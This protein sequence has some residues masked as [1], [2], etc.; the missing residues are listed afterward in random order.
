[1]RH[2]K[3]AVALAVAA[4]ALCVAAVPMASAHQFVASKTGKLK[5]RGFNE[6]NI[7]ATPISEWPE[8]EPERMQEF[9]FA[10][11]KILCF[12]ASDLNNETI[13]SE[14][15]ELES[16][17]LKFTTKYSKCA[18]YPFL[19]STAPPY[20]PE[21]LYHIAASM[22]KNGMTVEYHANGWVETQAEPEAEE[23]EYKGVLKPTSL[24]F[25]IGS[26]KICA[27]YVPEQTIPIKAIK[28]PEEEFS[29]VTYSNLEV[30]T[31]KLKTFPSGFQQRLLINDAWKHIQFKYGLSGGEEPEVK[32]QCETYGKE[33]LQEGSSSGIYKG[34]LEQEIG[35]GNLR[36]E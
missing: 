21:T 24:S 34:H 31:E 27:I 36:Y 14:V 3:L 35:G 22:S 28:K 20:N 5:G 16:N 6:I 9:H 13:H 17:V 19:P 32:Y 12:K 11:F 23:I 25:K 15:T 26:S 29:E 30:P 7:G 18:W 10:R 33:S 4:C 8:P 2:V 1:M